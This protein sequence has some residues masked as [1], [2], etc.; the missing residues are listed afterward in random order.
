MQVPKLQNENFKKQKHD[1]FNS[2]D[3]HLTISV[4]DKYGRITYANTNFCRL[5]GVKLEF[6]IGE[7]N[8]LLKSHLHTDGIYSNLWST[9]RK[10]GNWEGVLFY[11][12][13]EINFY[14]LKTTITPLRDAIG[15]ITGYLSIYHDITDYY[16]K[17]ITDDTVVVGESTSLKAIT[18]VI[19]SI[20]QRGKI[21]KAIGVEN[22][23]NYDDLIGSYVYD[24]ID[25]EYHQGAKHKIKEVFQ[26]GN[27]EEFQFMSSPTD[28][29]RALFI[30][31]ISPVSNS[32]EEVS[33]VN[34]STERKTVDI[35]TFSELKAVETKYKTIFKSISAG[36]I[37]ITDHVG[38]IVEWNKGAELTFG[39]TEAEVLG[40]SLAILIPNQHI[41]KGKKELFRIKERIK[42]NSEE[43]SLE[44]LGLKKNGTEFP[45]EFAGSSWFCG[46]NRYYCAMMLETTKRKSLENK[47]KQ[48]TIDL[49]T[50]LYRSA[51]D[52]KAPLT[53]VEGLLNLLRDDVIDEQL[54][55]VID[56][57]DISLEKGKLMLDNLAFA[58]RISQHKKRVSVVDFK[59]ELETALQA[60]TN[61][62]KFEDIEFRIQIDQAISFC[63]NVTLVRAIFQNIINNA[64]I[65]SKPLAQNHKPFI[66]VEI[67]QY[68][69]KVEI[70]ISDN[71][72]G[73]RK[74]HIDKIFNLYYRASN[75]GDQ[76]SGLGLYIVKCIVEDLNGTITASSKLHKGTEFKLELPHLPKTVTL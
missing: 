28:V 47:L 41:D 30:S 55:S 53:S 25:S 8:E 70:L 3:N 73:I 43:G 21:I 20:N 45:L 52:L 35:E 13:S 19:L 49:E 59:S 56:M 66:S 69:D 1:L 44:V 7:T 4:N 63:C 31:T 46:K 17:E 39:Y 74:K 24:F 51:H 75:E 57:L 15:T 10:G 68:P 38:T 64:I 72:L 12:K 32:L 58:S 65:Y 37:V 50:F 16:Q 62:E 11:K 29:E 18:D 14:W 61:L 26:D 76:G 34:I 42:M 67:E 54:A 23:K 6:L 36:A 5:L 27:I 33:F 2:L 60:L 48:K 22:Q 40:Q 71:G 9:I